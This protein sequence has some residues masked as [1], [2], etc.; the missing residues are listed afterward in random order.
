MQECAFLVN[1]KQLKRSWKYKIKYV[2]WGVW[3]SVVIFCYCIGKGVFH[4]DF[5]YMTTYGI[6]VTKLIHYAIYYAVV[7]TLFLPAIF[8]GKRFVCHYFCWVAPFMIIGSKIG[9]KLHT[10]QLH[11]SAEPDKCINCG[12]CSMKCPMSI[13]VQSAFKDGKILDAECIQCGDCIYCCPK[14]VLKYSIK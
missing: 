7:F 5:L 14:K 8:G 3:L 10:P 13:D 9:E 1:D 6:S 4:V 11:I 12:K 2:V